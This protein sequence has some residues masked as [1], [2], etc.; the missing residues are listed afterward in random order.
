MNVDIIPIIIKKETVSDENYMVVELCYE[1]GDEI[2][3]GDILLTVETS[4]SIIDI[5][6]P[7]RGFVFY[8]IKEGQEVPIATICA[9]VSSSPDIPDD[10]FD[11]FKKKAENSITDD[12][13]VED[14]NND[15]RISKAARK[16]LK[17]H[18]LDISIF[19]GKTILRTKDI[20]EYL[21]TKMVDTE[22]L[23][24]EDVKSQNGIII[25]GGGGHAK[26]CI[27]IIRQ[28]KTY[29]LAG[30]IDS[31]LGIGTTTLGVPVIGRD[32]E[33]EKLFKQGI[34][35]AVIGFGALHKPSIRQETFQ[36][37]KRIGYFLPNLI[38]PSAIIEPSAI[39]GEGNQIMAGSIIGSDVR[40]KNN[41]IINSGSIVSHDS[42][43]HNNVHITPGA[44]LAGSVKVG[45]NTVIGMGVT[46][47]LNVE[48]GSNVVIPNGM[49][50]VKNIS[51]GK[52]LKE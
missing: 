50:I 34:K 44:M 12:E 3:K 2:Q 6:S 21:K 28:M 24:N 23:R 39:L 48:I 19:R 14:V 17:E 18:N 51:H 8:N 47:L 7:S 46:I 10:Y 45:T 4:K 41:C 22:T 33:L 9:A 15:I 37:L 40:V 27:D 25:I 36:T 29:Y 52:F 1:D 31:K 20:D 5:E 11:R 49:N 38:H 43:L 26:M 42:Y 35:F 30:I 16:L 13:T 32:K